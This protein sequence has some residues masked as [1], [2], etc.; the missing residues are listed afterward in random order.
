MNPGTTAVAAAARIVVFVNVLRVIRSL[1]AMGQ[2]LIIVIANLRR[3]FRVSEEVSEFQ[4]F[5]VPEEVSEF[6][7][8]EFKTSPEPSRRRARRSQTLKH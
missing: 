2:Y 7:V 6:P 8:S 1:V 3:S 4:S 5:R